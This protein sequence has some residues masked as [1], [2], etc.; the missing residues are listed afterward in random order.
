MT[1]TLKMYSKFVLPS[2]TMYSM[3]YLVVVSNYQYCTCSLSLIRGSLTNKI[4]SNK[5]NE[6][7]LCN[8][9][10]T[11]LGLLYHTTVDRKHYYEQVQYYQPPLTDIEGYYP[12]VRNFGELQAIHQSSFCQFSQL[13]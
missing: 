1:P 6:Y 4:A 5:L 11:L 9:C 10:I 3:D 2:W 7:C 13:L 8:Y 12:I